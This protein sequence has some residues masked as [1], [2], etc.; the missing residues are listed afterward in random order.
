M[1]AKTILAVGVVAMII[2]LIIIVSLGM[3]EGE[4]KRWK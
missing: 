1:T 4:E 3:C 2:L